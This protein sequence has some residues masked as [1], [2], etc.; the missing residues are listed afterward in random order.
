MTG[1]AA[2]RLRGAVLLQ[3][4]ALVDAWRALAAVV[5]SGR[6]RDGIEPPERLKVLEAVL[7]AEAAEALART[8]QDDGAA[9]VEGASLAAVDVAAWH[10]TREVAAAMGISLRTA[11]RLAPDLSLIHI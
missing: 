7:R 6:R 5:E 2:V 8:R 4:P 9:G 11:Q 10:T 1:P 3:G